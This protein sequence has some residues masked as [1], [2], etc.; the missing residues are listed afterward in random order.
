MDDAAATLLT[1]SSATLISLGIVSAA[2][3]RGWN[4]WLDV[5][6]MQSADGRSGRAAAVP[7]EIRDLRE[8]VR[9][10][11]AIASGVDF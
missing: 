5:K 3:L 8:R 6:R 1:L 4:G 2:A 11:E 10:L 7:T 9:K